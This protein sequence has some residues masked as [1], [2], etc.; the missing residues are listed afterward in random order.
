RA[1]YCGNKNWHQI[2]VDLVIWVTLRVC[3]CPYLLK[4]QTLLDKT[5]LAL[6]FLHSIKLGSIPA[7]IKSRVDIFELDEMMHT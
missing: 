5:E 4:R 3:L 1:T 6:N 2:Q 7:R